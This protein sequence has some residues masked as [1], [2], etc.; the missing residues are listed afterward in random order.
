MGTETERQEK[1]RAA[2]IDFSR[3][4]RPIYSIDEIEVFADNIL[5]LVKSG[6]ATWDELS[7]SKAELIERL[8]GARRQRGA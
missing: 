4:L 5:S 7:F 1:K 8:Q 3:I 2:I 6:E